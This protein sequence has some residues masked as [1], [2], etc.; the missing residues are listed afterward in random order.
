MQRSGDVEVNPGPPK[1]ARVHS[2]RS[3]TTHH[4]ATVVSSSTTSSSHGKTV[5]VMNGGDGVLDKMPAAAITMDSDLKMIMEK[6]TE[7]IRRQKEDMDE[8]RKKLEANVRVTEDFR[9][10]A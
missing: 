6:Q 4:V 8:L 2:S 5:D 1:V 3:R 9:E 7:V 10:D